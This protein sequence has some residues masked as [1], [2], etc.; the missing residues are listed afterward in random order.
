MTDTDIKNRTKG[1]LDIGSILDWE[2]SDIGINCHTENG[3]LKVS[4]LGAGTIRVLFSHEEMDDLNPYSVIPQDVFR[5]FELIEDPEEI[6][7]MTNQLIVHISKTPT[8]ITFLTKDGKEI[9]SDDTG[10]GTSI[11]GEQITL[12]RKLQDGERFIGLGEKTGS[13]DRRGAG[14]ENWNT[15]HFAYDVNTDPIYA[16]IPFFIGVHNHLS[17]GIF[18]DNS[19]KSFFNFGASNDRF[20]SMAVDGGSLVY[21]FI[22]KEKVSDIIS[23]YTRL[24]GRMELP[25]L[26][27]IGYQQ[28]RYSYY[29][30]KE[31]LRLADKFRD[32][33]IPADVIVLDI[34]HMEKFKI[35]TWNEKHFPDPQSM[36]SYLKEKGF[37]VVVIC[38]PGIKIEKGYGPYDSGQNGQHFLK[39]SDESNY[40]GEVWPGWCHFPD[41]TKE[42]VRKWWKDNLKVYTD[43]GV[44]GLWCDMNEIATWG[45]MMPENIIF[46]FEGEA[47]TTRKGRNI[48]GMQMARSTFEGAK[49][50]LGERPF[51]LTRSAFAGTQRYSAVWTGDNV[52]T[53]EHMLLGVRLVNSLGLSGV[54]FAGYDVGGFAG[55]GHSQLFARWIQL[56]AFSP[57][58]RGHSMINSHDSEPWSYG[59]EVEEISKNFI[60]L[61]YKLLPYIY[62]HFNEATKSGLPIS[63]SLAINYTHDPKTYESEF[64]NQYLFGSQILVA[65]LESSKNIAKVFL[66]EGKWYDLFSGQLF[67]GDQIIFNE[68]GI[69]HLPVYVKASSVIP[70]YPEAGKNTK[71]LG[72]QLELHIYFGDETVSFNYYE[73]DGTSYEFENG[74]T[75]EREIIYSPKES[76][77]LL[78]KAVGTYESQ[79]KTVKIL[80]HG[81]K[82]KKVAINDEVISA[83]SED[84]QFTEP[85]SNFDPFTP[86]N[87]NH[88]KNENISS[89]TFR[90]QSDEIRIDL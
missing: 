19:Y 7:I 26:W 53:D 37:E 9:S 34:H 63:R 52:A 10:L 83:I 88:P 61:R 82:S 2:R 14:Y 68:C 54:P 77:V 55:N 60:K 79:M 39:Y 65:P 12:Y 80:L 69:T 20:S 4:V 90:H 35:F 67:D 32:Q 29:P 64:E 1:I 11:Q 45:Q 51:V 86:E 47:A 13:L 22:H 24:T 27:S 17:Y 62:S 25:P 66:P 74:N 76:N 89:F 23:S 3:L 33:E 71:S 50:N 58:F 48:Y 40:S 57:F 46:H 16:S 84:Y 5:N 43:L 81:F 42:E 31:V 70:V 18:L 78:S 8:R 49:R 30:Q 21:Y 28:C 38:D 75:F 41:F 73:D 72:G 85:I 87:K 56:G 6:R 15:D 59:E 44:K 36:V